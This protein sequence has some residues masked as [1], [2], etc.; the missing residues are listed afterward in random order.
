MSG[1]GAIGAETALIAGQGS[2]PARLV[3]A[4]P[5][6]L[7]CVPE[8]APAPVKGIGVLHFRVER[9]VPL[10]DA[11]AERGITRVCLAGA[12]QRPKLEPEMFDARTASLVPRLVG[13]MQAGDDATLRAVIGLFEE[14]GFEVIGAD[15]ICPDLVP[16]E[17]LICGT[18]TE[19]DRA[20]AE[21][22][23]E[24]V[25][26]LGAVDVGQGAVVARGLCLAVEALPG[27]DA[28]LDFVAAHRALAPGAKTGV[29]FKAPKPGQ[30]RRIDL[31][32]IGPNTVAKA[33]AAGLAGIVFEAGGV[34]LIDRDATVQAAE[35][36]GIFLWGRSA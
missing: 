33:A 21:R 10:F 12:M 24:I 18:L 32:A 28:M 9:L 25:S 22:A 30:D 31:P 35:A 13:A 17:G 7:V 5:E 4:A 3:A 1:A 26:A 2:L 11:L 27:T 19:E 6:M 34:L 8:G 20:D 14:F 29:F 36:A 16:V 23:A 15:A